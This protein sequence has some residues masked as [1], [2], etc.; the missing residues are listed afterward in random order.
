MIEKALAPTAQLQRSLPPQFLL[1]LLGQSEPGQ[2]GCWLPP[3]TL[4]RPL[5]A[6]QAKGATHMSPFRPQ[7]D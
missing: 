4:Q 6:S 3:Q 5:L 2:Q 7:H 1:L